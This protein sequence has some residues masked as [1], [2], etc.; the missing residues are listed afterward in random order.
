MTTLNSL[1]PWAEQRKQKARNGHSLFQEIYFRS[2]D[3][4]CLIVPER[5]VIKTAIHFQKNDPVASIPEIEKS[6]NKK[7]LN[8]GA[9]LGLH[10]GI[11]LEQDAIARIHSQNVQFS[12][13]H[14]GRLASL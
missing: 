9:F 3:D 13:V 1:S 4:I 6:G 7:G 12:E 11:R 10:N 5:S 2:S 14:A 8:T